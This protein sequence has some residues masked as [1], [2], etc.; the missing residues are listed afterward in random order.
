MNAY[1]AKTNGRLVVVRA[2]DADNAKQLLKDTNAVVKDLPL[3][4]A[5][6]MGVPDETGAYPDAVWNC[7]TRP[8]NILGEPLPN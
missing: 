6:T 5:Q 7:L 8:S 3:N 1:I 4:V 2:T